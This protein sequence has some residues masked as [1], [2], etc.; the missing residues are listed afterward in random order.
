M[1]EKAMNAVIHWKITLIK[2]EW[3]VK[4]LHT[5]WSGYLLFSTSTTTVT[6]TTETFFPP[7]PPTTRTYTIYKKRQYFEI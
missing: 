3:F 7:P 4:S 6:T 1:N 2:K 5:C